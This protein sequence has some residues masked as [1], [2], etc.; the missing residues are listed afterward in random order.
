MSSI[1]LIVIKTDKLQ[2]QA[3][4]YSSLGFQHTE[5]D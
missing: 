2:E 1:H 5:K 4:F 3:T